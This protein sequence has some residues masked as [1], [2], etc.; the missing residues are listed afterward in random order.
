MIKKA[1]VPRAVVLEDDAWKAYRKSIKF[2]MKAKWREAGD[3]LVQA[4]KL[5]KQLDKPLQSASIYTEAAEAYSKVDKNASLE[6]YR[7]SIRIYC[8]IGRFDIA[9]KLERIIAYAN[10]HNKHWEDA[11]VHFKKA[12]NFFAG[13]KRLDQSD[14]CLEK[15]AECMSRI[16]EY[17]EASK[18]FVAIARSCRNSN[19]RCFN[20]R[21]FLLKAIICYMG[22][23]VD[24]SAEIAA[25][26]K[27]KATMKREEDESN[28]SKSILFDKSS[29]QNKR[30]SM[31]GN[32]ADHSQGAT[33]G[34]RVSFQEPKKKND[35][36]SPGGKDDND[37]EYENSEDEE[38]NVH[39]GAD[40]DD[41]EDDLTEFISFEHKYTYINAKIELFAK[42]DFMWRNSKER[43]FLK[44]ILKA[45]EA[46][47]KDSFIDHIYYWNDVRP[48]NIF[49]LKL[50]RVI[51]FE[52]DQEKKL[53]DEV[54]AGWD[55]DAAAAEKKKNGGT[56]ENGDTSAAQYS[57][58]TAAVTPA[59]GGGTAAK[60]NPALTA[61]GVATG[62][63]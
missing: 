32:A 8:D 3:S 17:L 29:T 51:S 38:D 60:P 36:V 2:K 14:F 59:A 24:I 20:A 25:L 33:T 21:D 46:L 37:D 6:A 47:D 31:E 18:H 7:Q 1:H 19:L 54:I 11:A 57:D 23:S 61:I 62:A 15:A 34:N 16:G 50:L 56:T 22:Q 45:R 30:I 49:D 5:Q 41:G 10:Y 12:A 26:E 52:I 35:G 44:N 48:L 58:S 40:M 53:I 27:K 63:V 39:E 43:L 13:D 55:R 42:Y 4:A 9:G 28:R